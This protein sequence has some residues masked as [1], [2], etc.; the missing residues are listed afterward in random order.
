MGPVWLCGPCTRPSQPSHT[1]FHQALCVSMN[2]GRGDPPYCMTPRFQ[3]GLLQCPHGWALSSCPW[4]L[5]LSI[6][7]AWSLMA[8]HFFHH[9]LAAACF[10]P[11][12]VR[13]TCC[14][15]TSL[16]QDPFA[17]GSRQRVCKTYISFLF[18]PQYLVWCSILNIPS[19]EFGW[20]GLDRIPTLSCRKILLLCIARCLT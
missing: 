8:R 2:L 16:L 6:W 1:A 19:C 4:V 18:F 3:V 10:L 5:Q 12:P 11:F 20:N 13:F 14:Q 15:D 9:K 7:E 17:A